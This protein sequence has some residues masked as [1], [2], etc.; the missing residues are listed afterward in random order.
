MEILVPMA[1][2]IDKKAELARL[3][4]ELAKLN[5]E[6][7]RLNGKLSNEKFIANAPDDV[8]A[9]E[10]QKLSE[11]ESALSRLEEQKAKIMAL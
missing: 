9:K 3:D 10:R 6:R 7:G 4:K 8:V 11:V 1:G 2:V 5:K